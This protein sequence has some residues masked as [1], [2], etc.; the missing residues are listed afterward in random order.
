MLGTAF[1]AGL[2]SLALNTDPDVPF[3]LYA[4]GC[5]W[6]GVGNEDNENAELAELGVTALGGDTM[7]EPN[8]VFGM[9]CVR[10]LGKLLEF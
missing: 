1:L 5:D 9:P 2:T 10:M 8:P 3:A 4:Y 6:G 7:F